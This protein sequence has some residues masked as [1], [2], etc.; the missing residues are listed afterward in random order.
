MSRADADPFAGV[1]GHERAL[2][3]LRG[4]LATRR[5]P[6]G[7]LFHGDSGRGKNLVARR[8]LARVF[9]DPECRLENHPDLDLV[10]V[11]EGKTQIPIDRLR[12]LREWFS[13]APF[14]AEHRAALVDEAHLMTVEAQNSLLKLL[15]EPPRHGLLVLVTSEPSALLETIHSRLQRVHFGPVGGPEAE[16]LVARESGADAERSRAALALAQGSPGRA[17]ELLRESGE[18]DPLEEVAALLDPRRPPFAFAE[19]FFAPGHRRA[20]AAA[21]EAALDAVDLA[22]EA[23]GTALAETAAGREPSALPALARRSPEFYERVL[24]CLF[25]ARRRILG[26]VA[27]RLVLEALKIELGREM[28]R[29]PAAR[30]E[31]A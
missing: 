8:F 11:P 23:V 28:K 27:P 7:F 16:A 6:T 1:V 30:A 3:F 9:G 31:E 29:F 10:S 24:E 13:R 21:R 26:N 19:S 20:P 22:T 14:E 18:G 25:G 17:I 15:E 4:V 5:V 2:D 12:Q